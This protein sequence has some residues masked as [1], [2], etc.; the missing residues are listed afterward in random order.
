MDP[1]RAG[2]R[3]G[4]RL[5]KK[6]S[7]WCAGVEVR[8]QS[9]WNGLRAVKPGIGTSVVVHDGVRPLITPELVEAGIA[10]ARKTGAAIVAVPAR[11][12][13]KRRRP[14]G[15]LETLPREEIWLAQTPQTF[16]FSLLFEA[17]RKGRPGNLQGDG[18]RL[19]RGADGTGGEPDP[20]RRHQFKNNH[21]PRSCGWRNLLEV[22][23]EGGPP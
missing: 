7:R 22:F 9:V 16:Q 4:Q 19:P 18:R 8:Q 21:P 12:T 23:G 2:D 3:G 6:C 13:V 14:G 17:H 20:G 11:D 1:G 15:H 10:E 5:S